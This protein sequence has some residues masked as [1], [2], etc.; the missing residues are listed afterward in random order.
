MNFLPTD[1]LS[2]ITSF[3]DSVAVYRLWFTGDKDLIF[4]ILNGGVEIM[5]H[6]AYYDKEKRSRI[7]LPRFSHFT[8]L[9]EVIV[10]PVCALLPNFESPFQAPVLETKNLTELNPNLQSIILVG[11]S[12]T[13]SNRPKIRASEVFKTYEKLHTFCGLTTLDSE[14]IDAFSNRLRRISVGT[15]NI[16]AFSKISFPSLTSLKII[17]SLT[18]TNVTEPE[19]AVFAFPPNITELWLPP[20]S[21]KYWTEDEMLET[22][23]VFSWMVPVWPLQLEHLMV[24]GFWW[25]F[26]RVPGF[27]LKVAQSLPPSLSSFHMMDTTPY[28]HAAFISGLHR[29]LRSLTLAPFELHDLSAL[30]PSLTRLIGLNTIL[31]NSALDQL[32]PNLTDVHISTSGSLDASELCPNLKSLSL[33]VSQRAKIEDLP[34]GLTKLNIDA[35]STLVILKDIPKS[36]K[37][38]NLKLY[39]QQPLETNLS[40]LPPDMHTLYLDIRRTDLESDWIGLLPVHLS[41]F[42]F[43]GILNDVLL[44]TPLP[45]S[46]LTLSI[47]APHTSYYSVSSSCF[48]HLP[49]SLIALRISLIKLDPLHLSDLPISL[50]I[51]HLAPAANYSDSVTIPLSV[52][53]SLPTKLRFFHCG[54]DVANAAEIA[55]LI[56]ITVPNK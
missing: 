37:Q 31:K 25:R 50:Q 38:A 1:I 13:P 8:H 40:S 42:T 22:S 7:E 18:L 33:S 54:W 6:V 4:R 47:T 12:L 55:S 16:P 44:E 30:P 5:T 11:M 32:P 34:E 35:P 41:H 24:L 45:S 21:D 26:W 46:L 39:S 15:W 2:G 20:N 19:K 43:T 49:A 48:K 3:L 51:V 27:A 53:P 29:G 17:Q 14:G 56:P 10:T 52:I 36:L 23:R 9:R 28:D